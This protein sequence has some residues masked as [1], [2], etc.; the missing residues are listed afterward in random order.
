VKFSYET[1]K[2][3]IREVSFTAKQ[4]EITALAGPSGGG[5]STSAK[6]AARFWDVDSGKV[7]LGGRDISTIDPETLLQSYSVVFQDVV[8]FNTS[9][10]DNI[11]IGKR[12]ASDKEVLAAAKL[13]QCDDFVIKIVRSNSLFCVSCKSM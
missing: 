12:G 6:L 4:G 3:V 11:R 2:Q 5:K 7:L 1:G 9:I 8:L 13:A 10:M